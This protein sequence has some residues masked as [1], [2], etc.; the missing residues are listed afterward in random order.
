[1]EQHCRT[2]IISPT[3]GEQ[4]PTPVEDPTFSNQ[5]EGEQED[6][7]STPEDQTS[8]RENPQDATGTT[9]K[10]GHDN[11]SRHQQAPTPP[12]TDD[13]AKGDQHVGC[14][15]F[16]G[17]Q[18]VMVKQCS[19]MISQ[20]NQK[21]LR[22]F[23]KPTTTSGVYCLTKRNMLVPIVWTAD[24]NSSREHAQ[25][26]RLASELT[27]DIVVFFSQ[28]DVSRIAVQHRPEVQPSFGA[29]F[30]KRDSAL[31][32]RKVMRRPDRLSQETHVKAKDRAT[33]HHDTHQG[34]HG[35]GFHPSKLA[36]TPAFCDQLFMVDETVPTA[37]LP[38]LH[39]LKE[40][41]DRFPCRS[42]LCPGPFQLR[43]SC[44]VDITE[45][46]FTRCEV[47]QTISKEIENLF[48]AQRLVTSSP[49]SLPQQP[50]V[51]LRSCMPLSTFNAPTPDPTGRA[52]PN[53]TDRAASITCLE[54]LL[55]QAKLRSEKQSRL[56]LQSACS[57]M[58]SVMMAARPGIETKCQITPFPD[59]M[60]APD[61]QPSGAENQQET[62]LESVTKEKPSDKDLFPTITLGQFETIFQAWQGAVQVVTC[63]SATDTSSI[64]FLNAFGCV[65]F[66]DAPSPMLTTTT[67]V[68]H[69]NAVYRLWT[70]FH[71]SV[72]RNCMYI[73]LAFDDP[74]FSMG[75]DPP[76]NVLW[77]KGCLLLSAAA[78][79]NITVL[80]ASH[81]EHESSACL[82]SYVR[83]L[84][85]PPLK[86]ESEKREELLFSGHLLIV[87][88]TAHVKTAL[89]G[90]LASSSYHG[91]EELRALPQYFSAVEVSTEDQCL[92]DLQSILLPGNAPS[93]H[94]QAHHFVNCLKLV[95]SQ[96][97]KQEFDSFS[98][99]AIVN[100]ELRKIKDKLFKVCRHGPK[101][102]EGEAKAEDSNH[103]LSMTG[104]RT[105][106]LRADLNLAKLGKDL[107]YLPIALLFPSEE[108]NSGAS[109]DAYD[110]STANARLFQDQ[111]ALLQEMGAVARGNGDPNPSEIVAIVTDMQAKLVDLRVQQVK[112]YLKQA[113]EETQAF[114]KDFKRLRTDCINQLTKSK[115]LCG[116]QCSKCF[117]LCLLP[118][119]HAEKEC[120]CLI[121]DSAEHVCQSTCDLCRRQG[122][123]SL[124]HC[125]EKAGHH[126]HGD[127]RARLHL[128][129]T[130]QDPDKHR[131]THDCHM[132]DADGCKK[133]CRFLYSHARW[134]IAEHHC[135]EEDN[136]HRCSKTC[137]LSSHRGC[138]RKNPKC[139]RAH[140]K[141]EKHV[142]HLC[143]Q[144][145]IC[146]APC[147]DKGVCLIYSDD[148]PRPDA[149]D[150]FGRPVGKNGINLKCK[151]TI[152]AGQKSHGLPHRCGP[153]EH[154]CTKT[155]KMCGHCCNEKFGH[156]VPCD[157][158]HGP[159]IHKEA[160]QVLTKNGKDQVEIMPGL[161]CDQLCQS[162]GPSHSH[163]TTIFLSNPSPSPSH[164]PERSRPI[165]S[166]F[167][168]AGH[169]VAHELFWETVIMFRDPDF[170]NATLLAEFEKCTEECPL[171]V[172]HEDGD[173][174]TF[175]VEPLFH[176]LLGPTSNVAGFITNH[177]DAAKTGKEAGHHFRC[178]V[179]H[180]CTHGCSY[181]NVTE[182]PIEPKSLWSRGVNTFVKWA[183]GHRSTCSLP[184]SHPEPCNC[185]AKTHTCGK[186]CAAS[187][188]GC[189]KTCTMDLGE[190]HTT[191]CCC[192]PKAPCPAT[193]EVIATDGLCG[194]PCKISRHLHFLEEEGTAWHSC[195]GS[196][197]CPGTCEVPGR[198]KRNSAG[199]SRCQLVIPGGQKKHKS[200]C[201]HNPHRSATHYCEAN[202]KYCRNLCDL[203]FDHGM[204]T[205]HACA[206]AVCKT[207]RSGTHGNKTSATSGN[208]R[209]QPATASTGSGVVT[210]S[211]FSKTDHQ[212]SP[213]VVEARENIQRRGGQKQHHTTGHS[214]RGSEHHTSGQSTR[215]SEHHTSG[216][217][218]RGSE[219]HTS[220]QSTRGSEHHTSG[221]STRGSEHHTSGQS[222]RGSEQHH[223]STVY[224]RIRAS[225]FRTV[226]S[227]IRAS[228]F[229]TVYSRV[230]A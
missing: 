214:T 156:K 82:A 101:K 79:S 100:A 141:V 112:A 117:Y 188:I 167:R 177:R 147:S 142:D 185:G 57:I 190:S 87:T 196:H 36:E 221:Q 80:L 169:K 223:T 109:K 66:N 40:A 14:V 15:A 42:D 201:H 159:I 124:E 103:L 32:R 166:N 90:S 143:N 128:C 25:L 135:P 153:H 161:R 133:R 88:P 60:D 164:V 126:F 114:S 230:G 47:E 172:E 210:E 203:D 140:T 28:E 85:H 5:A 219:H 111:L 30:D 170:G 52:A 55:E 131:C 127:A 58:P 16:C 73:F 155:C 220:G 200:P 194:K 206:D 202:C 209:Q 110:Q 21:L 86:D 29:F 76:P 149:A 154:T 39:A 68:D 19:S 138:N 152:A 193:C 229:G 208:K 198:C 212:L 181:N 148:T 64:R 8:S 160:A 136:K 27:G 213:E 45:E 84:T 178:K 171:K 6:R 34:F 98:L 54:S 215:G 17:S 119:G 83:A 94:V 163:V 93:Y 151:E 197:R 59:G 218:T 81:H 228:H 51:V 38:V 99:S 108:D 12:K 225:H 168:L 175:C 226:Y 187:I 162:A 26:L 158:S 182:V 130:S 104:G 92:Q 173:D 77:L 106:A 222:T 179:T 56:W 33:P 204:D 184:F 132:H 216:Q 62:T 23:T 146:N 63:V 78:I 180:M 31:S 186:P 91:S 18:T 113:E 207:K 95:L 195:G 9:S 134:G 183:G 144:P 10:P 97:I 74:P 139:T 75:D 24:A 129:D 165:K 137:D 61:R 22:R 157:T 199:K 50:E 211:T 67:A 69:G 11:T 105:Q 205:P 48:P 44:V 46:L 123:R 2:K 115:T 41:F 102:E 116:K 37:A 107:R 20:D 53:T 191:F 72:E 13:A 35:D 125:K 176:A 145:H 150:V 1:M 96:A 49:G 121:S 3:P 122:L 43:L 7:K 227:R 120:T 65:A 71:I 192:D 70:A 217:S 118:D 4:D 174:A 189:S 89:E 224:S